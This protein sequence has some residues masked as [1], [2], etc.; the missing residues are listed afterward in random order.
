MCEDYE[1]R[2]NL[3]FVTCAIRH[4]SCHLVGAQ[5]CVRIMKK[6]STDLLSPVPFVT[7]LVTWSEYSC[8]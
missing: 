3:S 8:V 4:I 6:G 5:L 1:E 2:V 7:F